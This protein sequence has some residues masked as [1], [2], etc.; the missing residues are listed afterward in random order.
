MD[1]L[2]S[3]LRRLDAA[4]HLEPIDAAAGKRYCTTARC[5]CGYQAVLHGHRVSIGH[6]S[7][8]T[9]DAGKV[10]ARIASAGSRLIPC[11]VRHDRLIVAGLM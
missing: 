2:L 7:L 9:L 10:C 5:L 8:D 3:E 4:A 6:A 11:A 1:E